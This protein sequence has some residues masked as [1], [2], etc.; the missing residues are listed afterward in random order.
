[1]VF[2][3]HTSKVRHRI[4]S[5]RSVSTD[6]EF[7]NFS[8]PI[9][10]SCL[11]IMPETMICSLSSNGDGT[12][13]KSDLGKF[14][15]PVLRTRDGKK[16]TKKFDSDLVKLKCPSK[17]EKSDSY[18]KEIHYIL[19]IHDGGA[20][21]LKDLH[22]SGERKEKKEKQRKGRNAT[23]KGNILKKGKSS[24]LSVF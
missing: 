13:I 3:A 14:S 21:Y 23:R 19:D 22:A 8:C 2:P 4:S 1:M 16:I 7:V 17:Q 18:E 6:D 24:S 9:S 12:S 5:P 11:G 15:Y 20:Q 10:F